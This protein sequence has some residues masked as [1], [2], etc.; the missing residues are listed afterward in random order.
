MIDFHNHVLPGIDDGSQNFEMSISMLKEAYSQGIREVVNTV[1]L[2]HP[3]MNG[4]MANLSDMQDLAYNLTDALKQVDMDIKIHLSAEVY[5]LPNLKEVKEIEYSTIGNEK[6]MLIEFQT[7]QFPKNYK[8]VLFELYMDGTTPIIA[9]PER[10]KAIQSDLSILMD[11]IN[12]GCLIQ[13]DAGS[14]L[15]HFSDRCYTTACEIIK[16]KMCHVLG[17]DSHND[18]NRNF[19]L[20]KALDK[21]KDMVGDC[22]VDYVDKNPSD[23]INGNKISIPEFITSKSTEIGGFIS[24]V[25]RYFYEK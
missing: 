22:A 18:K 20:N 17:S 24:S 7:H 25:K 21:C 16:R 9:H 4:M 13:V 5:F 1:H 15:G 8:N 19:C 6:Y 2:Q 12:S 3:K 10:Y 11:L 23:L 14:L